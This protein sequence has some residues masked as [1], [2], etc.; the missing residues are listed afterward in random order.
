[1]GSVYGGRNQF[2]RKARFSWLGERT[3]AVKRVG[4]VVSSRHVEMR[5]QMRRF[6]WKFHFTSADKIFML[7]AIGL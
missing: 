6:F 4:M 5:F 7:T 3:G 1:M 2:W